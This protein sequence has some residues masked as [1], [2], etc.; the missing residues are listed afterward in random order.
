METDDNEVYS[1]LD[2]QQEQ[3]EKKEINQDSDE[4]DDYIEDEFEQSVGEPAAAQ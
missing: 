1:E 4:Y 2:F 3:E